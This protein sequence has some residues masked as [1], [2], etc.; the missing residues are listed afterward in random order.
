MRIGKVSESVLKRSILRQLHTRK[1]EIVSGAGVGADCAIFALTDAVM[2][3]SCM[4]ETDVTEV[5]VISAT[6]QKCA[7]NLA[8]SGAVPHAVMITLLLPE[9]I[10]E[11]QIKAIMAEAEKTCQALDMQ[12]AGGQTRITDGVKIPFAVVTG[13]GFVQKEDCRPAGTGYC[14]Q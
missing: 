9:T 13:Y 14:T 8:V 12:I 6:I 2:Q 7:N 3:V 5:S 4:R 11:P 1:T 10:E